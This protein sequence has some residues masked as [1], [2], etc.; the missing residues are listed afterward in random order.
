MPIKLLLNIYLSDNANISPENA[1]N[2]KINKIE[3]QT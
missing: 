2:I 1:H 3:N